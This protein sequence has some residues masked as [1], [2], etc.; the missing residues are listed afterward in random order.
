M[1]VINQVLKDLDR[2]GANARTPAGVIAVNQRNDPAPRWPWLLAAGGGVALVTVWWFSSTAPETQARLDKPAAEV[3]ASPAPLDSSTPALATPSPQL[4]LSD[5]LSPVS[6]P[7]AQP[8]SETQLTTQPSPPAFFPVIK[9][10][11]D[12]RLSEPRAAQTQTQTTVV[13][14]TP[15]DASKARTPQMQAE[16][17]WRQANRSIEQG[18]NHDA[19]EQ[20]EN[21][22][23]LEP[24]HVAGRQRLIGLMLQTENATRA[25]SLLREGIA[26]NPNEVWYPRSLAQLHLQRG[27]APQAAAILKASL[28]KRPD[29]AN[30]ALYAGA[31]T[32]LGKPA[33]AAQAYRDALQLNP[34]QGNWWIGLGVALE[35]SGDKAGAGEAYQRALQT[36]LGAELHDYAQQKARELGGR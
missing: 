21:L 22:L 24:G 17:A 25:E 8:V 26:I 35:Q 29:A 16:E 1:S 13:K 6:Q 14:A 10:R 18:R 7:A 2:Q 33:D 34:A 4:R 5:Q 27:D 9:P 11:L 23:R 19:Q 36:R 28:T 3:Q 12:L 32:K 30:W 20:L 15:S 31:S